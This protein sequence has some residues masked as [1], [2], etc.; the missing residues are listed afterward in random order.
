[1]AVGS[2]VG[3]SVGSGAAG[4]AATVSVSDVRDESLKSA[5][6]GRPGGRSW[7]LDV[8]GSVSSWAMFSKGL[9]H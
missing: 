5:A 9:V 4:E 1:M 2:D 7:C 8:V 3:C 6:V